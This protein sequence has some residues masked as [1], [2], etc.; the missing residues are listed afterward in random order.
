LFND[1]FGIQTRGGCA[2]AGP[3]AQH[4]L[5]IDFELAKIYEKILIEDDRF[6]DRYFKRVNREYSTAEILRPGFTR[7]SLTFFMDDAQVDFILGAV[8]FVCEHGWKLLP[9]YTFNLETGEWRHKTHL[10]IN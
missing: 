10:V 5:G 7:F 3:Y 1:L 2:C 6:T 4:L 8:K 9:L